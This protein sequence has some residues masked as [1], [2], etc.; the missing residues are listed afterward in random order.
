MTG[1]DEQA[2]EGDE[3]KGTTE[4]DFESAKMYKGAQIK[5]FVTTLHG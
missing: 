4:I 1:K 3:Q 2:H 5:R